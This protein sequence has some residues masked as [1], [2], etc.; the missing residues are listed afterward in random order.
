MFL[1]KMGFILINLDVGFSSA[2]L[3]DISVDKAKR[4]EIK[5]TA[6]Y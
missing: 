4:I 1:A 3:T 2:I 5:T 6:F